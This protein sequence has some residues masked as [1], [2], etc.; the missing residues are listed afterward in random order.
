MQ[1]AHHFA[2]LSRAAL[3]ELPPGDARDTLDGLVDYVLERRS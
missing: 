1:T 3:T 2:A